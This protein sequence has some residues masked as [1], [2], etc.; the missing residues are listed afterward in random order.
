MNVFVLKILCKFLHNIRGKSVISFELILFSDDESDDLPLSSSPGPIL[1][2]LALYL[3]FVLKMGPAFMMKR[4]AFKLTGTLFAYNAIQVAIS[5][6]L[7]QK[8][9]VKV[10]SRPE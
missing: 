3:L 2:I 5:L 10:Q 6:Y 9:N 1:M 7:V 4:P 8:V